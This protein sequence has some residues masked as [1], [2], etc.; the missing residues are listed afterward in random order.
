LWQTLRFG[1]RPAWHAE[2]FIQWWF[3]E[4]DTGRGKRSREF[5]EAFR[6]ALAKDGVAAIFALITAIRQII[7]PAACNWHAEVVLLLDHLR[8]DEAK[9]EMD[10]LHSEIFTVQ[11]RLHEQQLNREQT[12]QQHE[13]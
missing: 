3:G 8:L 7:S 4:D 6:A 13:R 1:E 10:R 9:A 11:E 2:L 12:R 5:C